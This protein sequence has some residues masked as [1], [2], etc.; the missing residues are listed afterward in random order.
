MQRNLR[1]LA[2]SLPSRDT[3]RQAK[4]NPDYG[5]LVPCN[6]AGERVDQD[7]LMR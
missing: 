7:L 3:A 1:S 2:P 5:W 4:T 6:D